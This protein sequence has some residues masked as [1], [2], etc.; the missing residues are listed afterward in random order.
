MRYLNLAFVLGSDINYRELLDFVDVADGVDWS[1]VPIS[2]GRRGTR[3]V[4]ASLRLT[5]NSGNVLWCDPHTSELVNA[6][7][8][9]DMSRRSN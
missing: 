3:S 1:E 2:E 5:G 7:T 9:R 4:D 8:A 6:R